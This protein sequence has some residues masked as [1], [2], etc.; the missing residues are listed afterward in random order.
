[1]RRPSSKTFITRSNEPFLEER[2]SSRGWTYDQRC[3]LARGAPGRLR[4]PRDPAT[5]WDPHRGASGS[6]AV[7]RSPEVLRAEQAQYRTGS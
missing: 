4:P 6:R 1:M 7:T 2:A 5:Q 3:R